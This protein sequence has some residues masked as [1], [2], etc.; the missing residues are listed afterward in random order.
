[1]VD[2][3]QIGINYSYLDAHHT[4]TIVFMQ[5]ITLVEASLHLPELIE[6]AMNG[7]EIII[8]KDEKPVVKLTLVSSVEK[9]PPLFGSAKDLITISDDFDAPVEDFQDYM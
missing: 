8:T 1:M 6:A 2:Y 7:E 5:Q 9:R 4:I 3:H